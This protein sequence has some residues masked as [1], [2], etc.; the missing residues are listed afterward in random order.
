MPPESQWTL[1]APFS[2]PKLRFTEE[3]REIV[4]GLTI[5]IRP[6]A[7][8][9]GNFVIEDINA[10]DQAREHFSRLRRAVLAA[11]LN[12]GCGIRIRH[13]LTIIEDN[14]V[15]L[16]GE[17]DQPFVCRQGRSLARLVMT[18]GDPVLQLPRVL[19]KLREG[20][21]LGMTS[22]FA[23]EAMRDKQIALACDLYMDNFFEGSIASSF[24]R[25]LAP[26]RLSRIRIRRLSTRNG[27]LTS[28][29][30]ESPD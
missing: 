11:S 23:V 25:S 28:G 14:N 20:I 16:P 29:S 9:L 27:L 19:P 10:I 2:A 30:A 5:Y 8:L 26:W 18:P 12:I 13:D 4:G 7:A 1:H 21:Q 24:T 6:G 22:D 17:A 15:Q 3:L